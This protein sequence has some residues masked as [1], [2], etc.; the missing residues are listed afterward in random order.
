M[1]TGKLVT[2]DHEIKFEYHLLE[3]PINGFLSEY[4]KDIQKYEASKRVVDVENIV[5]HLLPRLNEQKV[6]IYYDVIFDN[7]NFEQI[8]INQHCKANIENNVAMIVEQIK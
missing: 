2:I 7:N 8:R 6:D 3:K 4:K 5:P 1:K